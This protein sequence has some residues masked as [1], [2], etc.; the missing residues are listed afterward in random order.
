MDFEGMISNDDLL[1]YNE[2][3]E[4]ALDLG[5]IKK[6]AKT[7]DEIYIFVHPKTKERILKFSYSN[8]TGFV[9][10]LKFNKTTDYTHFFHEAIRKTRE[11]SN[12]RYT[13]CYANCNSCDGTLGYTYRYPNNTEYFRCY[14]ELIELFDITINEISELKTLLGNQL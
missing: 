13:G 2:L 10:H 11:E 8:K 6:R 4:F 9:V 12:F 14:Q 7:K 5:Y 3:S 1:I